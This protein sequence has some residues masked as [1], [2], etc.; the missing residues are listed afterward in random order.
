ME[1][2][3]GKWSY[4][5]NSSFYEIKTDNPKRSFGF[6]I[7]LYNQEHGLSKGIHFS[8]ENEANAKLIAEAG[9]VTNE[10][11]KSP[12]QLADENKELLEALHH[13]VGV[14]KEFGTDS[15]NRQILR[16]EQK[17]WKLILEAINKATK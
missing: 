8:K 15:N 4:K 9:T 5:K 1:H 6:N 3:S 14:Q 2:T 10:T 17:D 7:M 16:V 11:G 12:R 13:L